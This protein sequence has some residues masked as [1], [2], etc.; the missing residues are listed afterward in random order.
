MTPEPR[1]MILL[2][3]FVLPGPRAA[4]LLHGAAVVV[5]GATIAAVGTPEDM[6]QQWPGA[7]IVDLPE[8]LLM[9][10]L[11]NAH[12]HGRG[13][14]QIQLGYPDTYL[15]AWIAG[16]RARGILD[17]FALTRLAALR[18]LANGVTTTIHANYSYGTG[19]YENEVREQL[20]AYDDA[21]LRVAMCIGAMD[22]GKLVYPPHE[23]CFM[24]G[25]DDDL[26]AWLS[27]PGAPAYARSADETLALMARFLSD[28]A[29]HP[30]IRLC[31][32]PAGPQWV[33]DD[34]WRLIAKDARDKDLG[35][36]MHALESP[37]QRDA[38]AELYPEGVFHH[39][40]AL[41]A[42]TPR[43]VIAH[44][45]WS[46]PAD[47]DVLARTGA[48]VVR[49]PGCNMRMRNGIAPLA[50][51]LAHG[52]R[53]AIGT[54]NCSVADDEDLLSELRVG[55]YLAREPDWNGP[56]PP[57][58][59]DLL[60]MATV[61]GAVAAQFGG[62]VGTIAPG[63]RADLAAFS[64][65]TTRE[66][67]LDPDM[68]IIDAFLSRGQGRDTRLTMVEGRILYRDGRHTA[69]SLEEA[70]AVAAEVAAAARLPKDIRNVD[71]TRRLQTHLC[72][73]YQEFAAEPATK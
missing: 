32:G 41:G 73:H 26:R 40:D 25:L 33:S 70:A 65:K 12:Q 14:S 46:K 69:A 68:P 60:A 49:N 47:M 50:G 23:A 35:I 15:E 6:R 55:S 18:M 16:R 67:W 8:C 53:V 58:V 5:S 45:V 2:P 52:V 20:R 19:D 3:E 1:R 34:L 4:T 28:F 7:D 30:R 64:L 38:A 31:Y 21:G 51:Y 48:T 56:A 61:N 11:V 22:Q 62:E 10:G 59:D 63:Q 13:L 29:D 42:M 71:R 66:P 27:A 9:P 44:G 43:T 36:H 37:A 54:D 72:R 24:A 57:S 17:S 39:L